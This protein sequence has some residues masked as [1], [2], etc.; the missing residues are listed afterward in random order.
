MRMKAC[1]NALSNAS[2][3]KLMLVANPFTVSLHSIL[4]NGLK[5]FSLYTSPPVRFI[6]AFQKGFPEAPILDSDRLLQSLSP[7]LRICFYFCT[8]TKTASCI[9]SNQKQLNTT[10]ST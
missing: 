3:D 6:A 8:C 2:G 4:S 9:H 10:K 1:L 5:V 7:C